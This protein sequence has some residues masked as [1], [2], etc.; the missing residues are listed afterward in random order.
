[1]T[2]RMWPSKGPLRKRPPAAIVGVRARYYATD[3]GQR[4]VSDGDDWYERSRWWTRPFVQRDPSEP[5][6]VT[7]YGWL[8]LA[9]FC[10]L[11]LGVIVGLAICATLT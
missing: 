4:F 10:G 2:T 6:L 1:M 8:Y 5:Y 9:A 11:G 7:W 3:T